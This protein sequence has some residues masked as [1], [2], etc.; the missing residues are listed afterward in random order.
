MLMLQK[1]MLKTK[2]KLDDLL[3]KVQGSGSYV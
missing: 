3:K 1:E 2:T